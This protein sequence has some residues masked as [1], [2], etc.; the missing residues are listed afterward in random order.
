MLKCGL[1]SS[2]RR[3]IDEEIET[4][5]KGMDHDIK[6]LRGIINTYKEKKADK[7]GLQAEAGNSIITDTQEMVERGKV[8]ELLHE[9]VKMFALTYKEQTR[10]FEMNKKNI[11]IF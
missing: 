6:R 4:L 8:Q 9:A 7:L 5:M 10:Q 2:E 1:R 3:T 11:D